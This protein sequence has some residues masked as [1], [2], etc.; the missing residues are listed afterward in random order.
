M[1]FIFIIHFTNY[2]PL[3]TSGFL[4]QPSRPLPERRP[5]PRPSLDPPPSRGPMARGGKKA[6]AATLH[7]KDP[8][9][10]KAGT[11]PAKRNHPRGARSGYLPLRRLRLLGLL[12]LRADG[13][14]RDVFAC[15]CVSIRPKVSICSWHPG[16]SS[17]TGVDRPATDISLECLLTAVD[18]I[19]P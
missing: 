9:R 12:S 14:V 7:I 6:A 16:A 13:A 5:P 15:R 1:C 11:S 8:A 19:P 18:T 4:L 17:S 10:Y 3:P 2:W